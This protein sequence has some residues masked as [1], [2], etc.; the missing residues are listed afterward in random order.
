MINRGALQLKHGARRREKRE[1]R[2]RK[3]KKGKERIRSN[4]V[5]PNATRTCHGGWTAIHA[6]RAPRQIRARKRVLEKCHRRSKGPIWYRPNSNPNP[7]RRP[8]NSSP[9]ATPGT[10]TALP[11]PVWDCSARSRHVALLSF[12]NRPDDA[13]WG[14]FQ[15]APTDAAGSHFRPLI[16]FDARS[17]SGPSLGAVRRR[18]RPARAMKH[19]C[20]AS[21]DHVDD[22]RTHARTTAKSPTGLMSVVALADAIPSLSV[23][24]AGSC[25]TR[26]ASGTLGFVSMEIRVDSFPKA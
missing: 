26:T 22:P 17:P 1:R 2:K 8:D 4:T 5:K 9:A 20:A 15:A 24:S 3:P 23:F 21:N 16:N 10:K 19:H 7:A 6:E 12:P 25:D 18:G 13:R 11:I 14:V